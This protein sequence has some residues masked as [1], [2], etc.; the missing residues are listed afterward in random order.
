MFFPK[1]VIHAE[2]S[3]VP[4]SDVYLES[5]HIC[6]RK[7]VAEKIFGSGGAVLSVYYDADKTFLAAP[8]NEEVFKIIH[9]AKQQMLKDKNAAG[10]RSISVQEVLLDNDLNDDDRNLEFTAEEALHILRV[11]L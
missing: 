11:K 10:D 7:N 8:L 5:G 9:K 1:G 3:F 2:K 4:D 6:I